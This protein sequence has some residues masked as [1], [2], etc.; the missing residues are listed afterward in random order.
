MADAKTAWERVKDGDVGNDGPVKRARLHCTFEGSFTDFCEWMAETFKS[1]EGIR[2]SVL[3][4]EAP[5]VTLTLEERKNK[6]LVEICARF[7]APLHPFIIDG[8]LD[9]HTAMDIWQLTNNPNMKIQ[10]IKLVREKTGIGLKEAKDL[11]ESLPR[12]SV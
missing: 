9:E 11:Y 4:G 12:A 6:S 7:P 2:V 8:S 3:V 1:P 10:G 5:P